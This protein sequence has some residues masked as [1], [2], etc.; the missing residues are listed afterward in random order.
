MAD[1]LV[2][3]PTVSPVFSAASRI[4]C[5]PRFSSGSRELDLFRN[6]YAIF[7]DQWPAELLLDQHALRPRPQRDSN[8]IGQHGCPA[9]QF[10]TSG[11]LEKQLFSGH[12]YVSHR[13][14]KNNNHNRVP[15]ANPAPMGGG[16]DHC[17]RNNVC[18]TV[19]WGV[20]RSAWN[21]IY[22]DLATKRDAAFKS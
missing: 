19:S 14:I 7:T 18:E 20:S 1:M 22:H 2:P 16:A 5:A 8:G 11:T 17:F 21:G 9:Q 3:S 13:L 15:F 10:F 6:R 12:S 4:I